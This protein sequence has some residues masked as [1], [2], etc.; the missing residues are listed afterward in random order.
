MSSTSIKDKLLHTLTL[1]SAFST[2]ICCAL[3]ALFVAIG[4]GSVMVG[5]ITNVPGLVIVS[6]H[7]AMTFIFAGV[8]LSISGL[9]QWR[10]RNAACPI[11]PFKAQACLRLR[12]YSVFVFGISL[13][14]YL[15]GAYFAFIA[16]Y[17]V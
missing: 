14:A 12:K 9:M 6:K 16:K 10:N 3:P 2:L 4:A 13:F 11:D 1:F 5:L 17:F 7:K 8:M 15:T